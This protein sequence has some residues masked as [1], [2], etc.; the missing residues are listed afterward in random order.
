L[1]GWVFP[2]DASATPRDKDVE[3]VSGDLSLYRPSQENR[4]QASPL[5]KWRTA[6]THARK[7]PLS[8]AVA[9]EMGHFVVCRG[10]E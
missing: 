7:K 1:N 5:I 4:E 10:D 3:A 2:T 8:P 6:M 9:L